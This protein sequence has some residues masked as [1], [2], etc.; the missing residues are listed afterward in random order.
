M[1]AYQLRIYRRPIYISDFLALALA[2]TLALTLQRQILYIG[3]RR[4]RI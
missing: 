1:T 2:L 4:R 3:H